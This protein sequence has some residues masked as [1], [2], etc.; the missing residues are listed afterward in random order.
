MNR[1]R[2]A[3]IEEE[4]KAYLLSH[5]F[6]SVFFFSAF[7]LQTSHCVAILSLSLT[8]DG[9]AKARIMAILD[10][11]CRSQACHVNQT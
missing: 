9:R 4:K 3:H 5:F 8:C 6:S 10:A 2:S 7:Y 11:L 1:G